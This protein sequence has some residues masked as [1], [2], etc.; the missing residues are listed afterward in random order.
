MVWISVATHQKDYRTLLDRFHS[1][2]NKTDGCWLWTGTTSTRGY[3]VIFL[4]RKKI[5]A[6]RL[7]YVVFKGAL[8]NGNCVLHKC[9]NPPCV[10]PE[11]L[12]SGTHQDN[13]LDYTIKG[14][15]IKNTE[16][17]K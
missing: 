17:Q 2:I 8:K 11:H 5:F 16:K 4:K 14:K 3:G 9:D 7:S 13:M 10:N 6:H 12:F 15:R 1:R